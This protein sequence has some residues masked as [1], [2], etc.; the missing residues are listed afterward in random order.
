[1]CGIAGIVGRLPS[2]SEV[3]AC[4]N[5][6]RHR[7]PDHLGIWSDDTAFLVHSRLSIQDLSESGHQP[8]SHQGV[9]VIANGEIYNHRIL[10]QD[11]E[12]RGASFLSGSDCESILHGYLAWGLEELCRRLRGMYA[13]AIWDSRSQTLHLIRDRLG[14]KPLYYAVQQGKLIFASEIEALMHLG[15]PKIICRQAA[16]EYFVHGYIAGDLSIWENV[17][18]L[19]IGHHISLKQSSE[20]VQVPVRYWRLPSP[21]SRDCS[22]EAID[23]LLRE[24]VRDHL[25]SDRPVGC[26]L[27]GGVDSSLVTAYARQ[28]HRGE[29]KTFSVG[30]EI[31][32]YDETRHAELVARHLGTTHESIVCS[33]SDLL[34]KI[35]SLPQIYG[36]PFADSSAL[37]SL[38]LSEFVRSK[39]VVAL[40]GD[41]GDELCLGYTRYDRS[42]S[43]QRLLNLPG[44]KTAGQ[45]L[46]LLAPRG[47]K[48]S[49]MGTLMRSQDFAE[50]TLNLSGIFTPNRFQYLFGR[51]LQ[52]SLH[53][54]QLHQSVNANPEEN[55]SWVDAQHFMIEDILT[56]VDRASMHYAL[57]V[58]VPLL[59]HVVA[60]TLM[61]LPRD[62]KV[63]G[64]TRKDIL[65]RLLSQ[66]VPR[67]LWDRPKQGFGIPLKEW[68][69]GPLRQRC[70]DLLTPARCLAEGWRP[71]A[72]ADLIK[73]HMSGRK[74]NSGF[75]WCLLMWVM[76]RD[77]ACHGS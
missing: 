34:R 52:R 50:M 73:D 41:G 61:S 16:D 12:S 59:D 51:P 7:G 10:R 28:V 54:L 15:A 2:E 48:I 60:E 42:S 17:R 30:F 3:K 27:S 65:K 39:V 63:C 23:S 32:A 74:D 11:L 70:L 46:E 25:V 38:I 71:E 19:S 5:A 69:R 66:H 77:Q 76:W 67:E 75:L 62:R 58:R 1:M 33:E 56:K 22:D 31:H 45:L 29:L 8:F 21:G 72:V 20:A 37:P 36:E 24:T 68:F 64:G 53:W 43:L 26:F 13:I 57:E 55:W 44:R 35:D 6:L 47:N 40:S 49:R 9:H 18:K 14:I 4:A